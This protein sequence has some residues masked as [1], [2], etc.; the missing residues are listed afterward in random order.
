MRRK[1]EI[2]KK[3]NLKILIFSIFK[4]FIKNSNEIP[5]ISKNYIAHPHYMVYV[6]AKFRENTSICF[7]VTVRKLNGWTGG[8]AISPVPGRREIITRNI[9]LKYHSYSA[10]IEG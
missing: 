7:R 6:P 1:H 8:V 9:I 10:F 2:L 4:K 5:S 3:K